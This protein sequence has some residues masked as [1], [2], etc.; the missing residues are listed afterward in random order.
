MALERWQ[1]RKKKR[2]GWSLDKK[3]FWL[4]VTSILIIIIVIGSLALRALSEYGLTVYLNSEEIAKSIQEQVMLYA[5][6][7]IPQMI[8]DAKA[9]IPRII[10]SE[11][12][13][14]LSD[15][16]EIAGFVF[17]MP[18]ELVEQLTKNMQSNV[19]KTTGKILD[20]LNTHI[21]TNQLGNNV[22]EMVKQAITGE[23]QSQTLQVYFFDRIPVKVRLRVK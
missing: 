13:A 8:E 2:Y 18:A 5:E 9:E 3:S 10:E 20:G 11:V 16:M 22:Y 6:Q 1:V 21:L 4:G 15:R 12:Q 14:Q 19:A 17:T 23:L 7:E